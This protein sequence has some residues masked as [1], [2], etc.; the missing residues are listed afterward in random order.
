MPEKDLIALLLLTGLT[1]A[2]T[3]ATT[4]SPRLR[5]LAFFFS[6]MGLAF[7]ERLD[8]NFLSQWWYRGTTRGIELSFVDPFIFAVLFSCVVR[9][10]PDGLARIFWPKTLGLFLFYAAFCVF[11]VL[12]SDPK[13]FGVGELSK[14]F[15]GIA[16]FIC[17]AYYLRTRREFLIMTIALALI[18][19]IELLFSIRQRLTMNMDRVA[20]TLAH[21]NSLSMYICT[22]VPLL[23][24]GATST[25]SKLLRLLFW[26]ALASTTL[27]EVLTLSRTGTVVYAFVTLGTIAFCCS[28]KFSFKKLAVITLALGFAGLTT[29]VM[30]PKLK[31]RFLSATFEEEYLDINGEN[32]GIYIRCM[33][34]ILEDR[35]LGVGLNNWS[36]WVSKEYGN[37]TGAFPYHDYDENVSE[38]D[39][40]ENLSTFAPP[41]H[42]ILVLTA[43]EMGYPGVAIFTVLWIAWMALGVRYLLPWRRAAEPNY[44]W[45]AALCICVVGMFL[46][47]VTEWTYRQTTIHLT[48]NLALGGLVAMRWMS[49][50][51]PKQIERGPTGGERGDEPEIIELDEGDVV[52]EKPAPAWA[53]RAGRPA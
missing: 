46:H 40:K 33:V 24:A 19:H 18:A 1:L 38:K 17:G 6:V 32:R 27:T 29:G 21:P 25:S 44:R 28:W 35:F 36:Y 37:R 13:I 14:L 8:V 53:R 4:A 47:S 48:F 15:R 2:A 10:R 42:S 11:S 31:E 20:G 49:K 43:G 39:H 3:I 45:G 5:D 52:E 12:T 34:L 16:F 30:W 41:A 7:A 23:V 22:L 9:P 50:H 51:G 26:S